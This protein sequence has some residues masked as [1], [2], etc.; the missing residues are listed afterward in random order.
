MKYKISLERNIPKEGLF[1]RVAR[2]IFEEDMTQTELSL[3]AS[4]PELLEALQQL[5]GEAHKNGQ[6]NWG[7]AEKAIATASPP[8]TD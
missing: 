6:Y 4:A 3:I 7:K 8:E 2:H 1:V 5:V